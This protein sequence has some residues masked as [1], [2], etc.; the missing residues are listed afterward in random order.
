MPEMKQMLIFRSAID[1]LDIICAK[2][3]EMLQ[4]KLRTRNAKY[5]IKVLAEF[6]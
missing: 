2:F 5:S 6:P 4:R 1:R 3:N